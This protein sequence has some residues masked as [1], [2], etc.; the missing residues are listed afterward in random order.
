MSS[1]HQEIRCGATLVWDEAKPYVIKLLAH[2]VVFI[3]A[4]LCVAAMLTITYGLL[5][6]CGLLF[7]DYEIYVKVACVIG[8]VLL[9]LYIMR[10]AQR[11]PEVQCKQ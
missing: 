10:F 2:L 3:F 9:S 1:I 4:A 6:L 8:E 7:K 5:M 11:K